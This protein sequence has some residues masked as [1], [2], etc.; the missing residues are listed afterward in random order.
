MV[1]NNRGYRFFINLVLATITLLCIMPFILLIAASLT[2]ESTLIREGYS[3]F[4][5]KLS[6][7]AYR[8]IFSGSSKVL[9]GY[10]G[11]ASV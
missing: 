5:S 1:D 4:P 8:Y 7:D 2:E 10:D 9:R 11:T 3:F 6:L